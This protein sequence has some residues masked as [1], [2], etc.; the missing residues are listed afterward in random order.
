MLFGIINTRNSPFLIP[1][2]APSVAS[3]F[4]TAPLKMSFI[5]AGVP[6]DSLATSALTAAIVVLRGS[7]GR[8]MSG[9]PAA[10]LTFKLRS[11]SAI[12]YGRD[13]IL[14]YSP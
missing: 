10:G 4:G 9:P 8:T 5:E 3:S 2:I 7:G 6:G 14:F 13:M 12:D 11:S 1:G